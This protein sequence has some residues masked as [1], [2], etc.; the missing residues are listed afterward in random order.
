MI[1]IS[2]DSLEYLRDVQVKE[3]ADE[4]CVHNVFLSPSGLSRCQMMLAGIEAN[5]LNVD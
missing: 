4:E 3:S 2:I 1:S 5:A